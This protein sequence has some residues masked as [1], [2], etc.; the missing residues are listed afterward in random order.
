MTETTH[1]FLESAARL[2]QDH[3][4]EKAASQVLRARPYVPNVPIC[5]GQ[6]QMRIR[7]CL[8]FCEN[9]STAELEVAPAHL[10]LKGLLNF[11]DHTLSLVRKDLK[12]EFQ[13]GSV[14]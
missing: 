9:V 13:K 7:A 10:R 14:Q 8:A 2:L 3:S 12:E 4:C 6:D 5:S 11:I 1:T